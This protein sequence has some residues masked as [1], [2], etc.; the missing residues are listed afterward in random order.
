MINYMTVLPLMCPKCKKK[1][2]YMTNRIKNGHQY[3]EC[4][5]CKYFTKDSERF[6][7]DK[8][9]K[10]RKKDLNSYKTFVGNC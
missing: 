10:K 8:E 4:P 1:I 6:V 9:I 2:P 7:D 5:K 3:S